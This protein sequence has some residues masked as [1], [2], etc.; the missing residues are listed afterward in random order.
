MTTPT[1][2]AVVNPDRLSVDIRVGNVPAGSYLQI[3]SPNLSNPETS[4]D[5]SFTN[6]KFYYPPPKAP[7]SQSQWAE[8]EIVY[9]CNEFLVGSDPWELVL[10]FP[11]TAEGEWILN[12]SFGGPRGKISQEVAIPLRNLHFG[13]NLLHLR[14]QN[15]KVPRLSLRLPVSAADQARTISLPLARRDWTGSVSVVAG[16]Q[17]LAEVQ[18]AG[19]LYVPGEFGPSDLADREALLRSALAVGKSLIASQIR[20][21]NSPLNGGL[22]LVYDAQRKS[23][24]MAHW[25]WA[26][27]PAIH[28]LLELESVARPIDASL[29]DRFRALAESVGEASL[30]FEITDP[31]HP[32]HGVSTVRWEPQLDTPAG[33]VEYISTADNLFLA[34]WGWIS[35]YRA[36]GQQVYLDRMQRLVAAAERL[37]NEYPVVPQDFVV[38]RNCWTPHTLDESVFGMIGFRRLAELSGDSNVAS[39]GRRFLDAHLKHMHEKDGFLYRIWM[40]DDDQGLGDP[41]VKGH[42]WVFEGYFDAYRLT[43]DRKYLDLALGVA[44][45]TI[46]CQHTDGYWTYPYKIPTPSDPADDKGTAIWSYLFYELFRETRDPSHLAAARR[47]LRWCLQRQYMGDDPDL[48]GAILNENRMAYIKSRPMTILYTTTLFGL[49]LLQELQLSE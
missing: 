20:D 46:D 44:Q 15:L 21:P 8:E 4:K 25:L 49:A 31:S 27:G 10:T 26:W 38:E 36:T 23:R 1:L 39:V 45:K 32:A 17:N 30:L 47:A 16:G 37:V 7:A 14:G 48:H 28:L 43:G 35:L 6:P 18:A 2:Q 40:R 42:A 29:A 34:G 24:R 22:Y 5:I 13:E 12:G 33:L 11:A 9:F 19:V 41:D 3:V